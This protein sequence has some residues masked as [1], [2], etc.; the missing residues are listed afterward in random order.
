MDNEIRKKILQELN[1]IIRITKDMI[2]RMEA[3]DKIK[4]NVRAN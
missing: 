4:S 3:E 1:V 2:A